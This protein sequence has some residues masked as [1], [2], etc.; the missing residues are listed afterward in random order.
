MPTMDNIY[1]YIDP[2]LATACFQ[3]QEGLTLSN[4]L[5][6]CVHQT[7]SAAHLH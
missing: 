4:L 1:I 2:S 6:L 5:L 7:L 3:F